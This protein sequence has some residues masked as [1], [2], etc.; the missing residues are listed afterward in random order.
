MLR[1]GFILV[2]LVASSVCHAFAGDDFWTISKGADYVTEFQAKPLPYPNYCSVYTVVG[3][4]DEIF[5]SSIRNDTLE[6]IRRG[7]VKTR[8]SQKV[9]VFNLKTQTAS[10]MSMDRF[11]ELDIVFED[12]PVGSYGNYPELKYGG[13]PDA[14]FYIA[15][16]RRN[17]KKFV[18]TLSSK[19]K[20][21]QKTTFGMPSIIPFW[22]RK[23]WFEKKTFYSGTLFLEVFDE[24]RPS[25]PIV[26]LQKSYRNRSYLPSIFKMATW[27]QGSERP[28]LVV[29]CS[30]NMNVGIPAKVLVIRPQ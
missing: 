14:H 18:A 29:V 15:P 26:Q 13:E 30:G 19:G 4:P 1:N 3:R 16:I 5:V 24:K 28:V 12:L 2:I 25:E 10:T 6:G 9:Y 11:Q 8:P 27:A 7:Q 20:A 23:K 22:G 17:G 21:T